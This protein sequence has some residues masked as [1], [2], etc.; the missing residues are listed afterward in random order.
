MYDLTSTQKSR[1]LLPQ[2]REILY[3]HAHVVRI[4]KKY[5]FGT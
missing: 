4:S 3:S 5:R 2:G 1:L